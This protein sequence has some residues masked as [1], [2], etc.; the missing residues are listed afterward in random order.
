MLPSCVNSDEPTDVVYLPDM[1]DADLKKILHEIGHKIVATIQESSKPTAQPVTPSDPWGTWQ[2]KLAVIG[3]VIAIIAAVGTGLNFIVKSAI[4]TAL[5]QPGIDSAKQQ[6][7]L[8]G[9]R[10]DVDRL[11]DKVA[12]NTLLSPESL[13]S[14]DAR[15]EVQKAAEWAKDRKLSIDP[16]IFTML[17]MELAPF[18]AQ[19]DQQAWEATLALAAYHSVFNEN[20]YER[21]S[22]VPLG[23]SGVSIYSA[24]PPPHENKTV[25]SASR[26]SVDKSIGALLE[27]IDTDLNPTNKEANAFIILSGGAIL[28]DGLR[29]RNVVFTGVHV[30]YD[31]GPLVLKDVVFVNCTFTIYNSLSGQKLIAESFTSTKLSLTAS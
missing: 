30:V 6:T 9:I 19:N 12:K 13:A 14:K 10:K 31:G 4:T 27:P 23:S 25:M 2:K 8:D 11:L 20:P 22:V 29:G 7:Q 1:T 3:G 21:Q 17:P 16:K 28:L 15:A 24:P 5:V 18:V 26:V